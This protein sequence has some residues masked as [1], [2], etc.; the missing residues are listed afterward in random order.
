M[1][2]HLKQT[3]GV[4]IRSIR[5]A[6]GLTQEALSDR[7][8]A[9]DANF[10]VESISNIER[11]RSL[12]GLDTLHRMATALDLT[13]VEVLD[14]EE[15]DAEKPERAELEARL[16]YLARTLPDDRLKMAVTQVEVLMPAKEEV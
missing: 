15:T 7:M 16:R 14:I 1:R 5:L 9:D 12:P 10:S 6:Q 4:R 2:K 3:L 13:L 8:K 11:G